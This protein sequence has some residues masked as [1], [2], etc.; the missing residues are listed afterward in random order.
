[1]CLVVCKR[2]VVS[3]VCCVAGLVG[4]KRVKCI[5]NTKRNMFKRRQTRRQNILNERT[6]RMIVLHI[7]CCFYLFTIEHDSKQCLDDGNEIIHEDVSEASSNEKSDDMEDGVWEEPEYMVVNEEKE[8]R[9][10][11]GLCVDPTVDASD[12]DYQEQPSSA[13][14]PGSIVVGECGVRGKSV[15]TAC[16]ATHILQVSRLSGAVSANSNSSSDVDVE[17]S[18]F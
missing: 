3:G 7:L 8:Y 6:K 12:D 11:L 2:G 17:Q 16:D 15:L 13:I 9:Q 1:M 14:V 4:T 10:V 18:E 5:A